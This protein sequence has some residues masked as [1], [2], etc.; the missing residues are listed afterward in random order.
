MYIVDALTLNSQPEA[1]SG[2]K[3]PTGFLQKAHHSLLHFG[4]HDSTS[5]L[6]LGVILNNE[7]ISPNCKAAQNMALQ[8][9]V[10]GTRERR[11]R[12]SITFFNLPPMGTCQATPTFAN[13]CVSLSANDRGSPVNID[14]GVTN[15]P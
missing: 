11:K 13:Q 14:V 12:Q 6:R 1:Q 10:Y 9:L 4:A 2:L 8:R 7:I 15:K 3:E 5:A